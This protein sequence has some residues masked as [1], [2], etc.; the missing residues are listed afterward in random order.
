MVIVIL[1]LIFGAVGAICSVMQVY[2]QISDR[3]HKKE[4]Y[5]YIF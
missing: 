5:P 2:M 4:V 3:K 1:T